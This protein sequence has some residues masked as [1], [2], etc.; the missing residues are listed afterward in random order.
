MSA[1]NNTSTRLEGRLATKKGDS[2]AK[3]L[4]GYNTTLRDVQMLG[5]VEQRSGLWVFPDGSCGTWDQQVTA[6]GRCW[7]DVLG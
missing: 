1:I 5:G 2:I 4:R 3:R 7:I 6:L